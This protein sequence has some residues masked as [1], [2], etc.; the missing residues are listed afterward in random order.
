MGYKRINTCIWQKKGQYSVLQL[1]KNQ[2]FQLKQEYET[3][4]QFNFLMPPQL[5]LE[6]TDHEDMFFLLE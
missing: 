1:G 3:D 4:N 6:M 5:P 2:K